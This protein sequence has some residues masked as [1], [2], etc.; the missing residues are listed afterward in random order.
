MASTTKLQ[1]IINQVRAY[2]EVTSILMTGNSPTSQPAISI[3]NRVMQKI[4][5]QGLD[6]KWNRNYVNVTNGAGGILTVALQQDYVTQ[7]TDLA[8]LEQGWRIDINNSTNNG[9]LA[10]KP[11]FACKIATTFSMH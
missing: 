1:D 10:P 9:N 2:P 3:A 11:I 7:T 5:S 4:L 8:W 6:W